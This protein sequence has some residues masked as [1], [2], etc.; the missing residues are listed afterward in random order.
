VSTP[1]GAA[2]RRARPRSSGVSFGFALRVLA[3][4][5]IFVAG[6]AVGSALDDNPDPGGTRTYVRTL[7]PRALAPAA[8]TVTATVTVTTG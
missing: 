2:T 1:R 4:L 8:T 5:G 7:Q 6:S 3:L